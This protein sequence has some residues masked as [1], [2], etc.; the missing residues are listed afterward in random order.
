MEATQK[1]PRNGFLLQGLETQCLV[2]THT[3][4]AQ[5]N[6]LLS[7]LYLQRIFA[8]RLNKQSKQAQ[9]KNWGKR[10]APSLMLVCVGQHVLLYVEK[11]WLEVYGRPGRCANRELLAPRLQSHTETPHLIRKGRRDRDRTERAMLTRHVACDAQA[12]TSSG[13]HAPPLAPP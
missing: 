5:T 12:G 11:M 6:S 1:A 2:R 7:R 9:N 13:G 4:L 3:N 10:P 8:L